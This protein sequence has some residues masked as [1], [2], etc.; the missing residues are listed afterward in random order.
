MMSRPVGTMGE[1]NATLASRLARK[2]KQNGWMITTAESC[3]GGMLTSTLTDISGSSEWF[4]QGWVTYSNESKMKELGVA[5]NKF[6]GDSVPGAVSKDVAA[7]MAEGALRRSGADL[8]ISITGIAGPS[9][10][11]LNK[12]VGLGFVCAFWEDRFLVRSTTSQG[13]DRSMNK[14]LFV[15]LALETALNVFET[16]KTGTHRLDFR[17]KIDDEE[18]EPEQLTLKEA[19]LSAFGRVP[20]MEDTW[21]GEVI[22]SDEQADGTVVDELR[23]KEDE[24]IWSEE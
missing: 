19:T 6:E 13:G 4:K 21:Y 1:R 17:S 3:T 22:W 2:L 16:E 11:T 7:A 9:G 18:K 8:A 10:G 20:G 14:Q 24:D 12:P 15:S 5:R 23:K